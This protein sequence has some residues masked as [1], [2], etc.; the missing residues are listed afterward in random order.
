MMQYMS[1]KVVVFDLDDTLYKEIDFLK[2]GYL[3]VAKMV[4]KR[5]GLESC[6]VYDQLLSWY[7][8]GENAFACLNE[9]YGLNNPIEDYLNIYRFHQ[10]TLSLSAETKEALSGL[11]DMDAAMG[12][13]TDG[14]EITQ[15]QKI[16]AL[17]LTE[18]ISMDNVLI[19]VKK[20][21]FKPNNWSF[22]R[23]KQKCYEQY[24]DM[25]LSFYYVGDNPEKDFIVPNQ[26]GW[27]TICL[28]DDGRNIHHQNFDLPQDFLPKH[29]ITD[30]KDLLYGLRESVRNARDSKRTFKVDERI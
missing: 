16:E 6:G 3:E 17:G 13:I 7:Y 4:G 11:K 24:Q 2:S 12:I 23:M 15:K 20:A 21:H 30:I 29:K 8:K 19:N 5:Y 22:E 10:P 1:K 26:W 18:W 9:K 14:R 25:N 27:E 28:L